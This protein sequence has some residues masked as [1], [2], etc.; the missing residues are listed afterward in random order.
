VTQYERADINRRDEINSRLLSVLKLNDRDRKNLIARGLD[1]VTIEKNGYKSV[2]IPSALNEVMKSF[3][4]QDL[5]G[6]PGF[7]RRGENWRLNIGEWTSKKDGI[8]HSY[9]QGFLIP[10]RDVQGRIEGFQVRRA[11][12][13]DS[14]DPRYIWLSSSNKEHGSSSGA[15]IHFRNVEQACCSGQA[16]I[17]EGALKADTAAHLLDNK[18]AVI[19][20]AGVSSF[21]DDLGQRLRAQIPGLKQIIIT[22][23]ADA[24]RKPEVQ[25]ALERL[26]ETLRGAGLDAREL[27][28]EEKN[29]KGIDDYLFQDPKHRAEVK[30][31]LEE[32]LTS[33]ERGHNQVRNAGGVRQESVRSHHHGIGL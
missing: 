33:L 13:R 26:G 24:A 1:D 28:W 15:P 9:H 27:R 2:P 11:E 17:T 10:V 7:F 18:H 29:G 21:G 8:T 23:D 12:V 22:F 25:K 5:R 31:F 14:D 6:I 20:V 4:Q 3:K 30:S 32:S 16:I 19:A